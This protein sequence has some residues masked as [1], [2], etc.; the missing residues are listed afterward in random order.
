[1][2]ITYL[3]Y[4]DLAQDPIVQPKFLPLELNEHLLAQVNRQQISQ[5]LH[6][7]DLA[8]IAFNLVRQVARIRLVLEQGG[9]SFLAL[10][11]VCQVLLGVAF[12]LLE[13][14]DRG[15]AFVSFLYGV[16]NGF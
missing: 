3:H 14:F 2:R 7:L 10:R 16:A 15:L 6:G 8:V 4:L 11:H 5:L 13:V 12:L 1:M 9:Q